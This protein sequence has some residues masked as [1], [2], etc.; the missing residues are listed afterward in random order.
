MACVAGIYC[1][2]ADP[3]SL[4]RLS[5]QPPPAEEQPSFPWIPAAAV[6]FLTFSCGQAIY[7]AWADTYTI[8]FIVTAYSTLLAL[9]WC[10][11]R[12]DRLPRGGDASVVTEE[13]WLKFA[14]WLLSLVLNGMFSF[15]VAEML[16]P[17]L[18]AV[19]LADPVCI[20]PPPSKAETVA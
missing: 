1:A 15:R 13:K 18:A 17:A 4:L 2:K 12:L 6:L 9:F 14:V 16:P 20:F 8:S 7:R 11:R 19:P 5:S 10:L 3:K